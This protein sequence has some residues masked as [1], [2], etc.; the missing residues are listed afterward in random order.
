MKKSPD[1]FE[2]NVE[3]LS[4]AMKIKPKDI[5]EYFTDGRRVSF[6]LERRLAYEIVYGKL[7][8]SEGSGY[9]LI[10]RHGKLWEVRSITKGGLYFSPSNMVG[11]GRDFEL[12]GFLKKLKAVEGYILCDVQAFPKIPF[13]AIPKDT[14]QNWWDEGLLGKKTHISHKTALE[15][16]NKT[17]EAH[18]LHSF[19]S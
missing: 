10:D 1:S 17:I 4:K 8:P 16:I 6:I 15:L 3:E 12:Q 11:K 5:I 9:D 19:D 13:W 14:V 2:W 7:A 18:G